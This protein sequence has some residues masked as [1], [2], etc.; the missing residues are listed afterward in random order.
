MLVVIPTCSKDV[1]LAERNLAWCVRLDAGPVTYNALLLTERGT[2]TARLGPLAAAYFRN[3]TEH[4]Y[5]AY[6]GAPH[7]PQP[8]NY[9]WQTAARY[10]TVLGQPWFWWEADVTPL[11]PRWLATLEKEY[12]ESGKAFMGHVTRNGGYMSGVAIYPPDLSQHTC[13]ALLVRQTAFDATLWKDIRGKVHA[14]NH[15]MAHHPRYTGVTLSCKDVAAATKL[16]DKSYVVFHGI[17]DGSLIDLL[18]GRTPP[19]SLLRRIVRFFTSSD[20]GGDIDESEPMWQAEAT[21]LQ[22][23]GYGTLHYADCVKPVPSFQKQTPWPSGVFPLPLDSSQCYFNPGLVRDARRL[24]LVT[25]RWLLRGSAWHSS[26]V[27]WRL[28]DDLYPGDPVDLR[29]PK[30]TGIEQYEDPRVVLADGLFH[31]A[32]CIWRHGRIYRAH[33]SLSTF[34]PQWQHVSTLNV[35]YGGNGYSPGTGSGQEK[36]WTWFRHDNAWHFVYAFQPHTVVRVDATTNLR[37]WKTTLPVP[38]PWLY[39]EIRGGTPPVLVGDEYVTFF[40][41]SLPWRGR[42]KRY[43]AGAYAFAAKPPFAVTR[44]TRTPLLAGSEDDAMLIP[45]PLVI[46]PCGAVLDNAEWLVSFGVNDQSCGYARIPHA[47]LD[48]LLT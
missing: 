35:P 26:L 5:D 47:A 4:I 10:V 6:A 32:H 30:Y 44:M 46:F 8:Q 43:Y 15:L 39:G 19:P 17:N 1:A 2:D 24:W 7:W 20:V 9:A 37:E 28:D 41:S 45:A 11:K 31:V 14:A 12:V 21:Y 48:R 16:L 3:V 27:T 34:T 38:L 36:N 29:F 22:T 25:R 13:D 23:K 40:H 18:E 33:Q 42:R